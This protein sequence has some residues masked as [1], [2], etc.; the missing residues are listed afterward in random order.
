MT[1]NNNHNTRQ[2]TICTKLVSPKNNMF[3]VII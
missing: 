3:A 1:T 2:I